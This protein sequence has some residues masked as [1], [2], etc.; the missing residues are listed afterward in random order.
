[1]AAALFVWVVLA[2]WVFF[3]MFAE[4]IALLR[5]I[6]EEPASVDGFITETDCNDHALVHYKYR[7]EERNYEGQAKLGDC[8]TLKPGNN[9][10]I[11]YAK[12][13]PRLAATAE[14]REAFIVELIAAAIGTAAIPSAII[15]VVALNIIAFHRK[16]S[17]R[18]Q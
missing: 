16:M 2:C 15:L 3:G 4:N 1:M 17:R 11:Y 12:S 10:R 9:I 7:V 8:A 13:S 14:P 5:A 6:S 18:G